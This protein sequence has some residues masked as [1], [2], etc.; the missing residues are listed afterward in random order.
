MK[1]SKISLAIATA[2]GVLSAPAFALPASSYTNTGEFAG[3]TMNIRISGATAQDPGLLAASL[4]H[5]TPGSMH[6]YS[7]SNN[8]VYLCTAGP[9]VTPRAGATKVAIYKY[10]VGGSGAGVGPVN[11]AT[12]LPFMD[13]AKLATSCNPGT[14]VTTNADID[15]TGPL[16]SFVD[17]IC[18]AAGALTTNA[19]SYIGI[20]DV[21][22]AFFGGPADYANLS[23]G[24][25]ATVIFGVPV[26]KNIY[27]AMQVQQGLTKGGL[28]EADMPS[29]TQAQ[30]TSMFT[31]LG[32]T[33]AGLGITSNLAD[34]T[35]YVSRRA[36]TSGTQK[37]FEAVVAKTINGT[38]GA[39]SCTVD[40]DPFVSGTSVLNNTAADALC[41]AVNAGDIVANS[42]GSSQV[43]RCME[44]HQFRNRGAI[45]V[46]STEFKQTAAG[47][48]RFVKANM[49]APTHANVAEGSYQYYADASLNLRNTAPA[50]LSAAGYPAFITLLR[51]S[52]ANP[53]TIATIN[54]GNQTF[55]PSGLMALDVLATPIPVA[56]YTG[57]AGRNPWSR[58]VLGTLNN[59][60]S[61]RAAAF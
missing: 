33:W 28:T 44:G 41:N 24:A 30:I 15:G 26:T 46:V 34:D 19:V 1:F 2:C 32:Q 54:A 31:Q 3:D 50:T 14:N 16:P 45:G 17:V 25:L 56:D 4:T 47:S 7:I 51:N 21:E 42:S 49:K 43:I 53:A 58:L 37:T 55:G 61:G 59:C 35:V 29:L 5:C 20:S 39:K 22:P 38:S 6:R 8:F 13:L 9:L 57:A 11:G 52:F 36:D 10:S 18:S 60:Q 27:E 23:S 12:P 40:I 48:L